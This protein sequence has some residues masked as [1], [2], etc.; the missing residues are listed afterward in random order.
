[1]NFKSILT[2]TLPLIIALVLIIGI[3]VSCTL[4]STERDVPE[5]SN[6]DGIYATYT[7]GDDAIKITNDEMYQVLKNNGLSIALNWVDA[8]ILDAVSPTEGGDSYLKIATNDL[9]A[10]KEAKR[11]AIFGTEEEQEKLTA[12]EQE[13]AIEEY[14]ES[15]LSSGYKGIS[16]TDVTILTD[17]EKAIY[18]LTVAKENYAWDRLAEEIAEQDE[19]AKNDEEEDPYF[20]DEEIES[21]YSSNYENSYWAIVIP[22]TST[23]A[24]T[25]ALAQLG[26]EVA[27]NG[28]TAIGWKWTA[29]DTI[30]TNEE[31]LTAF[32]KLYNNANAYKNNGL[33]SVN[34]Q[35]VTYAALSTEGKFDAQKAQALLAKD[36][37]EG[38]HFFYTYD[39]LNAV[40]SS[41]RSRINGT[42]LKDF[43]DTKDYDSNA[44]SNTYGY[45]RSAYT[46]SSTY[47]LLLKLDVEE[48][49]EKTPLWTDEDETVM[50]ETVKAEIIAA[51]T[52]DAKTDTYVKE[53]IVELRKEKGLMFYDTALES[54]YIKS[55]D[56]KFEASKKENKKAV[57][58]VNGQEYS[59]D[60]YFNEL[61]KRMASSY[62][63]DFVT[64]EIVLL[65][66]HN[67]MI[68]NYSP[69]MTYKQ[70]KKAVVDDEKWNELLESVQA[71]KNNF[72]GNA[73]SQ[74]GFPSTYGWK[75]FLR[76]FYLTYYGTLVTSD[77]DLM[78]Y[79]IYQE[80]LS[81]MAKEANN[82]LDDTKLQEA[83][84]AAMAKQEADFFNVGGYHL[85]I[86]VYEADG[87]TL[88]DPIET[89]WTAEQ[90]A[91]AQALYNE[92]IEKI[93]PVS[94]PENELE[95]FVTEF[96]NA[97]Y[98]SLYGLDGATLGTPALNNQPA[99]D[100]KGTE[101]YLYQVSNNVTIEISKYKSLGLSVK[102]ESLSAFGA[103]KMVEQFE[104]YSRSVWAEQ[105]EAGAITYNTDDNKWELEATVFPEQGVNAD[106]YL[107]TEFGYHV[108]TITS[109]QGFAGLEEKVDGSYVYNEI[110]VPSVELLT[111]Y[112]NV[113]ESDEYK[114]TLES[115]DYESGDEDELFEEAGITDIQ[116]KAIET[117]YN[118]VASEITG[119]YV[120]SLKLISGLDLTKLAA[121]NTA[122]DTET[123]AT[124]LT[125]QKEYCVESM[126]YLNSYYATLYNV[127]Y[128]AE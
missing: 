56:S 127:E 1:M 97:P 41:V 48:I 18:A 33:E 71:L 4:I 21:Y 24:V 29:T 39:E 69:D 112:I 37:E 53:K 94:D 67:K 7:H 99:L 91:G 115:E 90:V 5:I 2:R 27:K 3:A 19:L 9:E 12:E 15:M 75:N 122:F 126:T 105:R 79:Y 16:K 110:S 82:Y 83:V 109:A 22:Y 73:F 120:T 107:V 34:S 11:E 10:L 49:E 40:N 104:D 50:D 32:V 17:E 72:A 77:E 63:L 38:Y 47:Y 81:N 58:V 95:E 100:D 31:V 114:E 80:A 76:D 65:S 55:H 36:G 59:T 54:A 60:E 51:L 6:Q 116:I 86:S 43:Y 96:N 23:S 13:E 30:L 85:L 61:S 35:E 64:K 103:G 14:A 74:Y 93:L 28:S 44:S 119:N 45:T 8:K 98:Y 62:V 42:A 52:E 128:E 89:G 46:A 25:R 118:A 26:I 70:L 101:P 84:E 87:K 111:K 20:T 117:Y 125:A 113:I 66:E 121:E 106:D 88:V 123:F 78:V 108:F 124:V 102:Y 57:L 92:I 68:S